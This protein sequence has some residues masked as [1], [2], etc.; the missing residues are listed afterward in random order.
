MCVGVPEG[1]NYA[2]D[3]STYSILSVWHGK[4]IDV[5]NMWRSRGE[6]QMAIPLGAA[7]ELS[8]VPAVLQLQDPKDPWIDTVDVINNR[9]SKRGYRIDPSGLP[10]FWYSY[11]ALTIED[12]LRPSESKSGWVRHVTV[13]A[14]DSESTEDIFF[15]LGSGKIIEKLPSGD[16]AIDDKEYYIS[17]LN[18]IDEQK[19]IIAKKKERYELL[20]PV[21][22]NPNA[23]L[24]FDYSI[25]W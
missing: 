8:G 19:L 10:V 18:G 24:K 22:G 3:L 2:Y 15:L 12:Y 23:P 5:G 20:L 16:Y 13:S 4:F 14:G 7:L 1:L 11:N 25:I 6:S 21:S 17:A 9:Y